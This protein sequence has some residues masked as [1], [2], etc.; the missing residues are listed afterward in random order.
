MTEQ[1]PVTHYECPNCQAQYRLVRVEAAA[2]TP[3]RKIT[4]RSCG[5]P[6]QAREGRYFLKYILVDRP[7]K[8]AR[9]GRR[10]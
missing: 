2:D 4:C 5:A 10:R 1:P 9:S 3:D 8:Q 7:T 6:L